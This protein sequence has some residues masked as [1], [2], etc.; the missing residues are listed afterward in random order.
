MPPFGLSELA[1]WTTDESKMPREQLLRGGTWHAISQHFT[2]KHVLP[3]S[4]YL[5]SKDK[6]RWLYLAAPDTTTTDIQNI[7]V[8]G[9]Q[10][11]VRQ[12]HI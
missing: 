2:V 11:I 4:V 10:I 8:H 6:G 1:G 12:H 7:T 9:V 5:A 3:R